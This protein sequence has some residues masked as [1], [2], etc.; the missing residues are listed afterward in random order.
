V[1]THQWSDSGINWHSREMHSAIMQ[2]SLYDL[3]SCTLHGCKQQTLVIRMKW[4]W[5]LSIKASLWTGATDCNSRVTTL[6]GLVFYTLQQQKW[7]GTVV[8]LLQLWGQEMCSEQNSAHLAWEKLPGQFVYL[9]GEHFVIFVSSSPPL[10]F[11]LY[12][13]HWMLIQQYE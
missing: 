8:R 3:L 4:Q 10:H 1:V 7:F 13:K 9:Q 2:S 12:Q 11:F 6:V 5:S